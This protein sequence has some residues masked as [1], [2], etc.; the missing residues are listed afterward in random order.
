M[1]EY[2]TEK[3]RGAFDDPYTNYN[4]YSN[5]FELNFNDQISSS[6]K[7]LNGTN[8]CTAF[9]PLFADN[10]NMVVNNNTPYE[11]WTNQTNYG[12]ICV[13]SYDKD[14]VVNSQCFKHNRLPKLSNTETSPSDTSMA[15]SSNV[16]QYVD[17]YVNDTFKEVQANNTD[18][19]YYY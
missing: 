6:E 9:K 7:R 12:N 8:N 18:N 15:W 5:A 19:L 14:N 17:N 13:N 11:K 10:T 3:L 2:N 16:D 1:S 4:H